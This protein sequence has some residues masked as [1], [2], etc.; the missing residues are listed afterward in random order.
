[1]G[2]PGKRQGFIAAE[3][4]M[5]NGLKFAHFIRPFFLSGFKVYPA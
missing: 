2:G 4:G 1:V 3:N 5:E